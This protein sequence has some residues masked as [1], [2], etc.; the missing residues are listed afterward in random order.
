MS[1]GE[2]TRE[3]RYTAL[4]RKKLLSEDWLIFQTSH[5]HETNNKSKLRGYLTER[6][7]T[8]RSSWL[9]SHQEPSFKMRYFRQNSFKTGNIFKTFSFQLNM[10]QW[11]SWEPLWKKVWYYKENSLTQSLHAFMEPGDAMPHSQG[12]S[13]NSN[14]APNQP[15]SS[16]WYLFL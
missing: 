9:S 14:P 5:I 15:N 4:L 8:F 11:P 12:L 7:P 13:N 1:R 2:I 3:N 16:Y 10:K 6:S